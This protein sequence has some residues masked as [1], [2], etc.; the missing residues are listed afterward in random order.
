M[1]NNNILKY[2]TIRHQ[3]EVILKIPPIHYQL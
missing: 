2:K 3:T 1:D